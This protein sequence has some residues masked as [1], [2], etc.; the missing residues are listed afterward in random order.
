M[1]PITPAETHVHC[2]CCLT[3]DGPVCCACHGLETEIT[4]AAALLGLASLEKD[5]PDCYDGSG[6]QGPDCYCHGGGLATKDCC[7]CDQCYGSGKVPVLPDLREPCPILH[8]HRHNFRPCPGWVPKQGLD[9][10][11]TAMEKDG[12]GYLIDVPIPHEKRSRYVRFIKSLPMSMAHGEDANEHIAAYRA[13][14]NDNL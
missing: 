12:W 10:L 4:P 3:L 11:Y 13:K 14:R 2:Y 8:V 7:P 1:K 5:C 9:A 6:I